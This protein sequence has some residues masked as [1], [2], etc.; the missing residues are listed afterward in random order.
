VSHKRSVSHSASEAIHS[1]RHEASGKHRI[2]SC[3]SCEN[4]DHDYNVL[5]KEG[6]EEGKQ[7]HMYLA[8]GR[9][10]SMRCRWREDSR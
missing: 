10:L 7:P 1:A 6:G 5:K 8:R 4:H 9:P 3:R 2:Q